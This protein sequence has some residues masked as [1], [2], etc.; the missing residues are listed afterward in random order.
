MDMA[1]P[2]SEFAQTHCV[3]TRPSGEGAKLGERIK[4]GMRGARLEGQRLGRAPLN[5]DRAAIVRDRIS[6]MSLTLVGKRHLV[7]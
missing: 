4:A 5:V 7:S 6:G 1:T 2:S 3:G